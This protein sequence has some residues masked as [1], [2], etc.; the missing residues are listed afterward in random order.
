MIYVGLDDTDTLEDPGT[1]QLARHLVRDLADEFDGRIIL[2]HQ[3]LEDPR[4]PCTKKNGCASIAFERTLGGVEAA[5]THQADG[6]SRDARHTLL[7]LVERIRG[8]MIP[9]CPA[10][11]DPGF[12]VA[13]SVPSAIIEWGLRAKRELVTQTEARRIAAEHSIHLEGLGGTE[14]GVIG[15]LAAIGLMATKNDGRVVHFGGGS[16]DRYDITGNLSVDEIFHRGVDEVI[17][18]ETMERVVDGSVDVGKR[19]R[20]NYRE[21]RI[22]LFVTRGEVSEWQAVRVT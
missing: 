21:G 6:V 16:E 11:S 15:A 17:V 3:L 20:P 18:H 12:C 13:T 14:E 1:N 7:N 2:R 8:L 19:L 22:V 9:W 5:D 10:G 4:V